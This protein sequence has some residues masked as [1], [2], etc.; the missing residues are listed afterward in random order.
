[1]GLFSSHLLVWT[2]G[3]GAGRPA[4]G[5]ADILR[6][7]VW[8]AVHTTFFPEGRCQ[9]LLYTW[10][11]AADLPRCSD[12]ILAPCLPNHTSQDPAKNRTEPQCMPHLPSASPCAPSRPAIKRPSNGTVSG[13]GALRPCGMYGAKARCMHYILHVAQRRLRQGS[14]CFMKSGEAAGRAVNN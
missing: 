11:L 5:V 2:Q 13:N 3:I 4:R 14:V 10:W 9:M 8:R 12:E 1:M 6:A 7:A